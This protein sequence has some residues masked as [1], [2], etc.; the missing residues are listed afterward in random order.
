VRELAQR[1]VGSRLGRERLEDLQ[2]VLSEVVANAVL[3]G[4]PLDTGQIVVT[5]ELDGAVVRGVVRDGGADVEFGHRT[6]DQAPPHLGLRLIDR[7]AD[8][9]GVSLNGEN[10]IWFE[11]DGVAA[12]WQRRTAEYVV[13]CRALACVN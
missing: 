11:M 7:L 5:I 2:V 3:R 6:D 8:D 10:A 9:W 13:D 1:I 4:S 12:A